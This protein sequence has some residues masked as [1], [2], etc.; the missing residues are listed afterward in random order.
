MQYVLSCSGIISPVVLHLLNSGEEVTVVTSSR[1]VREYCLA[2]KTKFLYFETLIPK[3]IPANNPIAVISA[4][5]MFLRDLTV[6][7]RRLD[8]VVNE[9]DLGAGD[10]FH[11]LTRLIQYDN[12]YLAK[13]FS[14]K[15]RV[16]FSAIEGKDDKPYVAKFRRVDFK[17]L[18]LRKV[19][20]IVLGLDLIFI[21]MESGVTGQTAPYYLGI[22]GEFLKRHGIVNQSRDLMELMSL[23]AV[24]TST[25]DHEKYD[26]LIIGEGGGVTDRIEY[27]SLKTVYQYLAAL[28]LEIAV[29]KHPQHD[30]TP[31]KINELY[32]EVFGDRTKLP[33]HIPVEL[34][35][36]HISKSVIAV[37]STHLAIATELDHLRVVS[38]LEL[39]DWKSEEN[40]IEVKQNLVKMSN[41]KI[42]F[43]ET[44]EDLGELM[45]C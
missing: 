10:T 33:I 28:P 36:S 43:P 16:C 13:K 30:D 37:S 29:K 44:L 39:L 24:K 31:T 23:V 19:L 14:K 32:D 17:R 41:S 18:L 11:L 8:R 3:Y 20:K 26:H 6:L 4:A 42:I 5:V 38:L 9:I 35:F 25:S 12:F 27:D 45:T 34:A 1:D 22:D 15:G 40:K 7:K 21:E 2:T